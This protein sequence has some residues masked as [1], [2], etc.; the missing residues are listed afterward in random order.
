MRCFARAEARPRDAERAVRQQ[1]VAEERALRDRGDGA[2]LPV[3][4]EMQ[5][6][7]EE[8]GDR[9][10]HPLARGLGANID[11]HIVGITAK[12]VTPCLQH[13]VQVVQKKVGE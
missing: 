2:F 10:H 9:G 12:A 11:V 8:F 1:P 3:D 13:L 4:L 5:P 7:L 6:A